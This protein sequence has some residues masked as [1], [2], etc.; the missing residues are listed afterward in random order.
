MQN[1]KRRKICLVASAGGHMSQLLRLASAWEGYETVEI[2]TTEH[3][4]LSLERYGRVYVV[5]EC[6]REHP[7]RV[8]QVAW[9]CLRAIWRERPAVVISTGAAAGC[10]CCYWAK[11][12]G[13]KVIWVDSI[14]NTKKLSMSGRMV[15]PFAELI[16]SQWPEVARRYPNVEY[17]GEVI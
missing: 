2:T 7:L 5:G 1:R 12:F 14:A 9:R 6:N 11:L 3:V 4:R 15:R 13:A 16:L 17:A 10:L 8:L